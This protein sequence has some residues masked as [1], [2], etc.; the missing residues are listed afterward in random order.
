MSTNKKYL[1]VSIILF[2]IFITS[3]INTPDQE[4]VIIK[5][6]QIDGIV[7]EQAEHQY[8]IA[9]DFWE[10][11]FESEKANLSVTISA[12]VEVPE[13]DTFSIVSVKQTAFSQEDI[14]NALM[15]FLNGENLYEIS[16]IKTK[17]EIEDEIVNLEMQLYNIKNTSSENTSEYEVVYEGM[18]EELKEQ[19]KNAPESYERK[20]VNTD[21]DTIQNVNVQQNVVV[22]DGLTGE[23]KER[24]EEDAKKLEESLKNPSFIRIIGQ[25]YLNSLFPSTV[26]ITLDEKNSS[27]QFT[28]APGGVKKS[29]VSSK[30]FALE[31]IDMSYEDASQIAKEYIYSLGID[32]MEIACAEIGIKNYEIQNSDIKTNA[33]ECYIFYFK[34]T[35][36]GVTETYEETVASDSGGFAPS[37]FYEYIRIDVDDSGILFFKWVAPT[38]VLDTLYNNVELMPFEDIKAIFKSQ[39]MIANEWM[40]E[41]DIISK[42]INITRIELGMVR[43]ADDNE[44]DKYIL[45][46]AWDFFGNISI[47]YS[48]YIDEKINIATSLLTVNAIDGSIIDRR[49]GY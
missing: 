14:D 46:P 2:L 19:L 22:A 13:S 4:V 12:P 1:I 48:D 45:I 44:S 5:N 18:I 25:A 37:N 24:A 34:R 3:C 17:Q 42:E 47:E 10:D 7:I 21:I 9:E 43:I 49:L 20:L 29:G 35:V 32:Y 28:N 30:N 6:N 36:N 39:I 33:P 27:I 41:S 38:I 23:E 11:T 8:Y 15:V 26:A 31:K 40:A 16:E